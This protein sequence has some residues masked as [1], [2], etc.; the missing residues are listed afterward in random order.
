MK[1][2]KALKSS[3]AV[4]IDY[5]DLNDICLNNLFRSSLNSIDRLSISKNDTSTKLQTKNDVEN[6]FGKTSLKKKYSSG[7]IS[8]TDSKG[9]TNRTLDMI[10]QTNHLLKSNIFTG[11][12]SLSKTTQ[13]SILYD[14][15]VKR[16]KRSAGL[17]KDISPSHD[18]LDG[19]F[20]RSLNYYTKPA[21]KYKSNNMLGQKL[22]SLRMEIK[23]DLG[24]KQ[25]LGFK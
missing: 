7:K 25:R 19:R 21:S 10:S 11:S 2:G 15:S 1:T 18:K 14:N 12:Y 6:L 9:I 16:D 3:L 23:D 24:M 4:G 8:Y 22:N 17:T 13:K 5:E 20:I